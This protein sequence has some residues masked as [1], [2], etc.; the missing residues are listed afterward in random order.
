MPWKARRVVTLV[1]GA[2]IRPWANQSLWAYDLQAI[3]AAKGVSVSTVRRRI[4]C[5]YLD[6]TDIVSVAR[7]LVGRPLSYSQL[8]KI[9][10]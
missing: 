7:Y 1:A 6:P 8:L 4:Q 5:G 3:A 2:N 10:N 9:E